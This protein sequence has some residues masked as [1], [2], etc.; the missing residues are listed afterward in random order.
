MKYWKYS[1][2][3]LFIT[4]LSHVGQAQEELSDS[5]FL[6]QE[7][8]V[9]FFEEVSTLD[10]NKSAVFSAI[11]PGLGQVYNG[12]YWKVPIIYGAFL[13]LF[14]GIRYNHTLYSDF[15]NALR[16]EAD[17]DPN[18]VNPFPG[19]EES[20]LRTIRDRYQRDRDFLI[21]LTTIAYL[22]NIV[23]AHVAA[24]LHEFK[25]NKSLSMKMEPKFE[26]SPLFSRSMGVSL[27]FNF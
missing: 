8:S 12:Q 11:L 3:L 13:G 14:H 6:M 27:T 24:H 1:L 15:N 17:S 9:V 19:I 10:P 26:S 7:D 5:T 21:I 23:E 4:C 20:R 18:T 22:I 25:V 16:A 2:V